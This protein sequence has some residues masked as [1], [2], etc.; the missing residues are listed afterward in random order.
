[1]SLR[2]DINHI[3]YV[4]TTTLLS[5]SGGLQWIVERQVQYNSN[6]EFQS[7]F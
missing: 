5:N 7:K 2:K 1:M 3:V 6:V 4:T